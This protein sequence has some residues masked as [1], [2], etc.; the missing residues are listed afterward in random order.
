MNKEQRD[1]SDGGTELFVPTKPSAFETGV[2]NLERI[3]LPIKSEFY[4]ENEISQMPV[5]FYCL[6]GTVVH[7][8]NVPA[9][10]SKGSGFES[11]LGAFSR[12]LSTRFQKP[13][14]LD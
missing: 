12:G 6:C 9:S 3:S 7:A 5:S 2:Q 1:V 13:R 14:I 11:H 8:V 10:Q 4:C